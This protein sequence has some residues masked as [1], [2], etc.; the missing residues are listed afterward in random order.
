MAM[1]CRFYQP[2]SPDLSGHGPYIY[3]Y[4]VVEREVCAVLSHPA[5]VFPAFDGARMA[6]GQIKPGERYLRVIY[7]PEPEQG[8]V[9]VLVAATLRGEALRACRKRQRGRGLHHRLPAVQEPHVRGCE[10]VAGGPPLSDQFP[11]EWNEE[12]VRRVIA[13]Y[14]R[15]EEEAQLAEVGAA[16]DRC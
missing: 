5:E 15:Q 6:L 7:V 11:P 1:R 10:P 13:F 9:F 8:S 2:L 3:R 12:R 14:E 16:L 4:D